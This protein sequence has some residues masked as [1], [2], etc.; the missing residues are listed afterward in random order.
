MTRTLNWR[1][2]PALLSI[3][4][5]LT[6][7]NAVAGTIPLM[8]ARFPT[9]PLS[10]IES[11][12][13]IPSLSVLIFVV[14]SNPIAKKLGNKVTVLLG[15]LIVLIAGLIPIVANSFWLILSS[16][17]LLGAGIGLFNAMAY[18]LISSYYQGAKRQT[19]MGYQGSVNSLGNILMFLISSLLIGFGWRQVYLY[20]LIAIPVFILFWWGAPN[21]RPAAENQEESST[22][23]PQLGLGQL[24]KGRLMIYALLVLF[25]MMIMQTVIVKISGLILSAGYGK[26]ADGSIALA[27]LGVAN[28]IGGTL[29]GQIFK[30][31]HRL[32]M[33]L[34]LLIDAVALFALAH[35]ESL[36][37]TYTLT[38][39]AGL[40]TSLVGPYL[41]AGSAEI[42]GK[43]NETLASSVLI[44]GI[45]IGVFI[46]PYALS[47]LS[48]LIG[49]D[50]PGPI[51]V[52]VSIILAV[53]GGLT[54]LLREP[55]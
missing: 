28:M 27:I 16:R 30:L 14:L 23:Q 29:Y 32:I 51:L 54:F 24:L 38:T 26:I 20:Y 9:V 50:Q 21:Q 25:S 6:S 4:I 34:G 42:A 11:L 2:A 55:E 45:N 44:V 49:S 1:L 52:A 17:F 33:P 22:A 10:Q 47:G 12:T 13:T 19:M 39:V 41:F 40:S 43:G 3:S 5:L 8:A 37:L 48:H 7:A 35:S 15:V 36:W 31:L 18:S 46:T 53:I